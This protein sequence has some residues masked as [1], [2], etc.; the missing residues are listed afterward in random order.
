M[1]HSHRMFHPTVRTELYLPPTNDCP[2]SLSPRIR[3]PVWYCSVTTELLQAIIGCCWMATLT[4]NYLQLSQGHFPSHHGHPLLA[5]LPVHSRAP[6]A[7]T[8]YFPHKPGLQGCTMPNINR[9]PDEQC[10]AR[11]VPLLAVFARLLYARVVSRLC[12][13]LRTALFALCHQPQSARTSSAPSSPVAIARGVTDD[14]RSLVARRT[15]E[16]ARC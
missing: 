16:R 2:L 9:A 5:L 1:H 12:P 15:S 7:S 14:F 6:S 11:Y 4:P 13:H 8:V 3:F 10:S